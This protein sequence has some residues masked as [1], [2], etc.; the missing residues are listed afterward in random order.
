V[1]VLTSM[2]RHGLTLEQLPA[3]A[4]Y[5]D[6]VTFEGWTIHLPLLVDGRYDEAERLAHAALAVAAGPLWLSHLPSD[7]AVALARAMGGVDGEPVPLRQRVG[8]RLWLGDGSFRRTTATVMDV[9]TVGRGQRAGYRQRRC[10][11]DGYVVVV[12]G[13]TAHGIGLEAP[14]PASSLRQRAIALAT[15]TLEAAGWALSPYTIGG[16]KRWFLEPPHM[17]SS[18]V[19]LP[20]AV[21]PPEIG[22]EV[23]VELRLTTATVDRIVAT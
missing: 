21:T 15:G 4:K 22:T 18:L 9:H 17:Q 6:R 12:A 11:A 20:E 10:P 3:V 2:R 5:L 7:E 14:T 16:R 8:T 19:F 1:E 23:P 13:G